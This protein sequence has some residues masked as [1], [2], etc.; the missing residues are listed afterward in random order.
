MNETSY[1]A[2]RYA[3]RRQSCVDPVFKLIARPRHRGQQEK[4]RRNREAFDVLSFDGRQYLSVKWLDEA[5]D[6]TR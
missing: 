5:K 3:Y 2:I 6:D 1:N 4:R